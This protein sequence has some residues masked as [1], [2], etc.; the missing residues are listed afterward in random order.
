[1]NTIKKMLGYVWMLLAPAIIF[2]LVYQAMSKIG[3]ASDAT[4]ANTILQWVIILLIF[5][6]ICIGFFIFGKYASENA[7]DHLPESS[8]EIE[9]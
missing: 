8:A 7:Y 2:F 9:E 5:A 6:P 4:R 1:M 3:S